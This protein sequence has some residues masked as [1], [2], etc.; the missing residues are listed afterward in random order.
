M[1]DMKSETHQMHVGERATD[2]E[3][4][5]KPEKLSPAPQKN[6]KLTFK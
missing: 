1:T 4:H 5:N 3:K 2:E 6:I